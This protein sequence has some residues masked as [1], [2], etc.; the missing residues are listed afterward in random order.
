M[1]EG[2]KGAGGFSYGNFLGS[3]FEM[4]GTILDGIESKNVAFENA[5]RLEDS[6]EFIFQN[7]IR[8]SHAIQRKGERLVGKQK[9][10]TAA[11]GIVVGTGSNLELLAETVR[12]TTMAASDE[13]RKGLIEKRNRK[14]QANEARRQGRAAEKSAYIK[15]AGNLL[16]G[17]M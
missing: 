13:A 16:S 3:V 7:A 14:A 17:F 8:R 5:Q 2:N 12:N 11:R 4:T 9:A 6:G 10:S 15:A 1:S